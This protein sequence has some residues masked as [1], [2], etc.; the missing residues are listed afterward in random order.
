MLSNVEMKC[1]ILVR[2]WLLLRVR[3]L[4]HLWRKCS[5]YSMG[6]ILVEFDV[7]PEVGFV[8]CTLNFTLQLLRHDVCS[9]RSE[10]I[11][12]SLLQL[13]SLVCRQGPPIVDSLK[14]V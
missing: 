9:T 10:S 3:K 11:Q 12:V 6:R 8:P 2:T 13:H 5:C 14:N 7:K 4:L 1:T